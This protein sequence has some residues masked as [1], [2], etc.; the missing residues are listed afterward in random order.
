MIEHEGA[1]WIAERDPV[2]STRSERSFDL[3]TGTGETVVRW[4]ADLLD[5]HP[6]LPVGPTSLPLSRERATGFL[7]PGLPTPWGSSPPAFRSSAAAACWATIYASKAPRRQLLPCS[8]SGCGHTS[9]ALRAI[10][11]RR[12]I[13]LL[14]HVPNHQRNR[15]RHQ[16]PKPAKQGRSHGYSRRHQLGRASPTSL[17]LSRER[18]CGVRRPLRQVSRHATS[19][20]GGTRSISHSVARVPCGCRRHYE[21]WRTSSRYRS[22]VPNGVGRETA[23]KN[24]QTPVG[25]G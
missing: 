14:P 12:V 15:D 4:K 17:T 7:G 1:N 6:T 18:R 8:G 3:A 16:A 9:P 24:A 21:R 20:E 22:G 13:A 10:L 2:E 11:I 25:R 19:L 23:Q 5:P